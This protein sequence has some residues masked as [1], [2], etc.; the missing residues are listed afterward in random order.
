MTLKDFNAL[1]DDDIKSY[2]ERYNKIY[3]LYEKL[4]KEISSIKD[5]LKRK[6]EGKQAIIDNIKIY[7]FERTAVHYKDVVERAKKAGL[8]DD[9]FIAHSRQTTHQTTIKRSEKKK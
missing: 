5:I 7:S 1:S 4:D 8:I 2:V 3:P 6:Y 9:D